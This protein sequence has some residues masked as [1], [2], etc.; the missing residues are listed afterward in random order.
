VHFLGESLTERF[1]PFGGIL[2]PRVASPFAVLLQN[3]HP[4]GESP[5]MYDAER[6][7]RNLTAASHRAQ[8]GP[9]RQDRLSCH[10]VVE[11]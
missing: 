6:T 8:E 5:I 3:G 1:R 2:A 4:K 10:R 9:L 11:Y 7:H